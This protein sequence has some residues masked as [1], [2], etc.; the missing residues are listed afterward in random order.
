MFATITSYLN[1]TE[2]KS[3]N[4][5]EA[6]DFFRVFF[7][8]DI[9]YRVRASSPDFEGNYTNRNKKSLEKWL[10]FFVVVVK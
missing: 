3:E 5:Q 2:K 1:K 9:F 6:N 8:P 4:R 7:L 10:D